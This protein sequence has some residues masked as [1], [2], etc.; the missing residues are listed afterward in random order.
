[1]LELKG[2]WELD[3]KE[4]KRIILLLVQFLCSCWVHSF[5]LDLL[6]LCAGLS[7]VTNLNNWM[8]NDASNQIRT[9]ESHIEFTWWEKSSLSIFNTRALKKI[10]WW[11]KCVKDINCNHKPTETQLF[12]FLVLCSLDVIQ[13][14]IYLFINVFVLILTQ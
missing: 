2:V 13:L 8:A 3:L 7:P 10:L 5:L 4:K 9:N 6:Q 11:H 14:F 1:M 12:S